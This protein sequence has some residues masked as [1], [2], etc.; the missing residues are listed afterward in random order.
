MFLGLPLALSAI[1]APPGKPKTTERRLVQAIPRTPFRPASF[2]RQDFDLSAARLYPGGTGSASIRRTMPPVV[3]A[4]LLLAVH[5]NLGRVHVQHD[6]LR[7]VEG[8]HIADQFAVDAGR[9]LE[10]FLLGPHLSLKSLQ[11]GSQRR[12]T[13]PCLLRADQPERWILREPLRVV[14]I[15]IARNPAVYGLAQQIR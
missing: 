8:F 5:R 14:D 9:A 3:G 4:L 1:S 13:I 10:V 2:L 6:A 11:A 7:G 12:A 15:F